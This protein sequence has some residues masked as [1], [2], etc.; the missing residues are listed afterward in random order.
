MRPESTI[1]KL[2]HL[3]LKSARTATP[4]SLVEDFG[5][6]Q[7]QHLEPWRRPRD[8]GH[9]LDVDPRSVEMENLELGLTRMQ[10]PLD[11]GRHY[12]APRNKPQMDHERVVF[13]CGEDR[14]GEV[15]VYDQTLEPGDAADDLG[16]ED[17]GASQGGGP[18]HL[19]EAHKSPL[20][21]SSRPSEKMPELGN[22][23]TCT[24]MER[25]ISPSGVPASPSGGACSEHEAEEVEVRG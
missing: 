9:K 2:R 10:E 16:A 13:R 17:V 20:S 8:A 15:H 3:I 4:F 24:F 22:R 21:S 18:Y 5:A 1:S 12:V 7:T 6:F 23:E 11:S 25:H 19:R 14:I